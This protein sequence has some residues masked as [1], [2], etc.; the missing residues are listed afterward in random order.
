MHL[1][2]GT[3]VNCLFARPDRWEIET[4]PL[5]SS[6]SPGEM[7]GTLLSTARVNPLATVVLILLAFLAFLILAAIWITIGM[8][9]GMGRSIA[10]TVRALTGATRALREGRLDHRIALEGNDELW[11]VAASFNEMAEGLE[12]I[13]EIELERERLEQELRLARDIQKRL[14]PPGPPD[15]RGLDLAGLSMPARH[16]GGRLLRLSEARRW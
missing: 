15:I 8:V 1:P 7:I 4:V 5:T 11:N 9:V 14:L 12:R 10:K 3:I 2:G 13:S 16:V 6:A